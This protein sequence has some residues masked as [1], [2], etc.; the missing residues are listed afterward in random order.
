MS[1]FVRKAEEI[2]DVATAGGNT[3]T[4][5]AILIDRQGGLRMLDSTGWSLTGL[6]AEYGAAA[7]YK[8]ERR[9]QAVRVE[10]W[11]GSDRCLLQRGMA[12]SALRLCAA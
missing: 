12:P 1:Q 11:N 10:G 8:I 5:A 7:V 2:L 9:G 3:L 6:A 4:N